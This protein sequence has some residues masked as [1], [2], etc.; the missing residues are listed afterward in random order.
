MIYGGYLQ[1]SIILFEFFTTHSFTNSTIGGTGGPDRYSTVLGA[2]AIGIFCKKISPK[3]QKVD[4]G[5][6]T[7]R[8]HDIRILIK[9]CPNITELRLHATRLEND[10]VDIIIKGFF[11]TLIKLD[12]P[13]SISLSALHGR[14][15]SIGNGQI[16]PPKLCIGDLPN[17][18]YFWFKQ[19][20]LTDDEEKILHR[21]LPKAVINQGWFKV[22]DPNEAFWNIKCKRSDI[23][24]IV[25]VKS[26]SR[27]ISK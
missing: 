9:R 15:N 4:L 22:A 25:C 13:Y 17:L 24:E 18:K 7:V 3:L 16:D 6:C 21:I 1:L 23:F 14:R 5:G 11:K 12:F 20:S 27:Y 10:C 2:E 19:H 8:N 26:I